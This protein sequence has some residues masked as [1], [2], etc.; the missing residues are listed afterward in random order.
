MTM[1]TDG[2]DMGSSNGA[3][4][5]GASASLVVATPSCQCFA[6]VVGPG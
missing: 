5:V 4:E 3:V 6:K 1:R 2:N